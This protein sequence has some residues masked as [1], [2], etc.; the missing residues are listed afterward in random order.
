MPVG[1]PKKIPPSEKNYSHLAEGVAYIDW[2]GEWAKL[3][4]LHEHQGNVRFLN[5]HLRVYYEFPAIYDGC[6]NKGGMQSMRA[7]SCPLNKYK[8]KCTRLFQA[9]LLKFHYTRYAHFED[10]LKL[11]FKEWDPKDGVNAGEWWVHNYPA[12]VRLKSTRKEK[13]GEF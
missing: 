1:W 13:H 7:L 2:F 3:I 6:P 4:P 5:N 12:Y 10:V 11:G 8:Y 9:Y